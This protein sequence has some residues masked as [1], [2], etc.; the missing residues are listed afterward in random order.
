MS[1]PILAVAAAYADGDTRMDGLS[2]L[3]VK[4]T[5][6]LAAIADGLAACGVE[7]VIESD[8]LIVKGRNG[9]VP[10]NAVVAVHLDH[11]IAMSFLVLG[12]AAEKPV[13]VD[14]DQAIATSYPDFIS[15]M[16]AI[17]ATLIK[18]DRTD[19]DVNT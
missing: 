13:S 9:Q 12:I 8:A 17:G 7:A 5:D 18:A 16:S 6:R 10:G 14:D 3:R 1:T 11:R 15:H 4:E 2:E 19:V